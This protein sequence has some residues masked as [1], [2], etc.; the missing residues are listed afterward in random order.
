MDQ[1]FARLVREWTTKPEFLSPLVDHLPKVAGIPSPRDV[2]GYDIGT[3]KKLTYYRDAVNYYRKLAAATPRVRVIDIGKTD[4][5]R[6]CVIVFV[7]SEESIRDLEQ[8]RQYLA[9]L[10]D[11]RKLTDPQARDI[12][13]NAKPIYHLMGGLHSAETGPPEMLMELAYRV[14]VEDSP[15]IRQ[16]R[17]NVIVAITP[18]AEPDG[19]D[20][21]VD[22][23]YR[24]LIDITDERDRMPAPPHW[25][26]YVFHDNNRDINYSQIT[27]RRLLDW[28]LQWH[29]PIM[30]ELHESVPFLYTFSGQ[31]PQNPTLDPI[32]YAE[33]PWFS[34]FEMA[35]MIKYGMPGVWTHAFVDMWSPGYLGFMSSNH[36]GMLRMYET[37][38]NG[39]A[40]T[41]KRKIEGGEDVGGRGSQ[42]TR[43]WYRPLPPYK[44][45]V[46]SMRNNTNYMQTGVLSALQLASAFPRV[47]LENFYLKSRHSIE[48]GKT[49]APYGFVIPSGQ[50]DM[51]RL[52]F[53]VNILRVQGIEVGR[54]RSEFTIKEGTFPAGSYVIKRDQPYGRLAK[55]LLEKQEYPDPN[56]RTYD[57]SGWTM[58]MM[59][60]AE[61]KESSDKTLLDVVVEPVDEVKPAGS[62]A[63]GLAS[64]AYVVAHNGSA[65]LITLRYRLKDL[66]VMAAEASFKV[67]DAEYPAGSFVIAADQGGK[68]VHRA[69]KSGVEELGLRARALVA[70]PTVRTHDVDL[71]RLAV[72]STWGSTQEVGWVRHA[73]DKFE[74]PYDLIYKERI[75][76][77][78]LRSAYDAI[79]IPNQGRGGKGLVYD[80]A[81]RG[82]PVPYTRTEQF[83][84][85]GAYGESED[86]TGG[87]GLEGVIELQEFVI[88][89]GV[90]M[91]LGAASYFP[92][93][94]GLTPTIDAGRPSPQFYAPGPIV[95][96]EILQAMHPIF[97]GYPQKT[98][99]VRYAN[100]PL[101]R[102]PEDDRE[103]QVLMR[104]PGG[105]KGVLSGLMKNPNEIRSRP[106]I[107]DVPAGTGRV[108]LF[109]TNP[110]YRWQNLGEFNML[111][112]ALLHFNDIKPQVKTPATTTSTGRERR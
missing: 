23:Y 109:A 89:G 101:L 77:G 95:E 46:W 50:P 110:T 68:D 62:L 80:I 3:P 42:T 87:M 47:I 31:A 82:K 93:E 102:V 75:R 33:L 86:I 63:G 106:A 55:I 88:D 30:H 11:P 16:I 12:I 59:T 40:T 83:P 43:E 29:P 64:A 96:A 108:L 32:L 51:T 66:K 39:G 22:W 5:G 34:N 24:H 79:V 92:P 7:G 9:N 2:L 25:G 112:N 58:G 103:L 111:F 97:Y 56:L 44:E 20:R 18:V 105:D 81:R 54:A 26:K 14:A 48:S 84:N 37:F 99:P 104:F 94:F 70:M 69:V 6:E 52:A 100:G 61:V 57:D 71:P 98:V 49:D 65:N 35:Q 41:M 67:G 27:M 74:V 1:D 90:L 10:A 19:R 72:F 15:I 8:H 73:L 78:D 53:L 21:Y 13:A 60:H 76:Q 91:T 107:V 45:V 17:D 4:E 36:N 38:G 28:Y 85:L